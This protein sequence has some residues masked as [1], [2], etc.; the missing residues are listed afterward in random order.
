MKGIQVIQF[1]ELVDEVESILDSPYCECDA[2][3]YD[4]VI[5]INFLSYSV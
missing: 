4:G 1:L 2:Y 5:H 3:A